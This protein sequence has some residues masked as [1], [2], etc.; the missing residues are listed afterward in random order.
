MIAY[1]GLN[2]EKCPAFIATVNNDDQLRAQ[3]AREWAREYNAPILPGHIN[4]TGCV[5]GGV[6]TYYCEQLC[7]IRKCAREKEL[8]TCADC[9]DYNCSKLDE[10]FK[11]APA[12]RQN[13][14]RLR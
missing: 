13:L 5:A 1:C 14:D 2:C 9:G 11:H 4:C 3:V 7:E 8:S 12:A 6:K 10:V